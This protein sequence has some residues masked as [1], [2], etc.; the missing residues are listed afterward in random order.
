[1]VYGHRRSNRPDDGRGA[2]G[3]SVSVSSE[4]RIE[5]VVVVMFENRSFDHLLGYLAHPDPSFAGL[6]GG[7]HYN[8]S[9][10]G[11]R[12]DVRNDGTPDL[13]AP[14][15][16]YHGVGLQIGKYGDVAFNGGFVR[17]YEMQ[18]GVANGAQV[19]RCLDPER[20]CPVL[21]RLALQFA[22]C[23]AWFSSVPGETW[24]NRNFAHAATSD[25]AANIE[26]GF[27]YDPTIFEQ[28]SSA[29][30]RWR[31]YH[32]GPPQAWC[33]RNLWRPLTPSEEKTGHEP[34]IGNWYTQQHFFDHIAADDLP[35]YAFIEP[36]H[37]ELDFGDTHIRT[38]SQ[39]PD[40]NHGDARDF[41][42][43][44]QLMRSI[45]AALVARPALFATTLLVITYDEHGGFYDHVR[46]PKATPPADT[47]LRGW[48]RQI[49][50][51]FHALVARISGRPR[52]YGD[53]F[54]FTHLGVRVPTI[55]ISPWIRPGTVVHT[56]LEHAS[57]PATLRALFAPKLGSLTQRDAKAKTFH[58]VVRTHATEQPRDVASVL[59]SIPLQPP[60]SPRVPGPARTPA[61]PAQPLRSDLDAQLLDLSDRVL[62]ELEPP[63]P[64]R[65][66]PQRTGAPG[67]GEA[68]AATS[69]FVR[70]AAAARA[71]RE[72]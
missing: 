10:A 60:L 21:A 64:S 47:V 61:E 4:P 24:P 22:V 8:A 32:D 31:I 39:H 1:M 17:S 70:A 40:H 44:E 59:A 71:R 20:Q 2:G 66:G 33:F 5:H 29:G 57:I 6:Q 19:M 55:L 41:H 49:L 69:A 28:L 72:R 56:Q 26:L 15:H 13:A 23:D 34:R 50:R 11:V 58:D 37:V 62:A 65:P 54:D 63:P 48:T 36:A 38:N 53:D 52:S 25:G 3:V 42:A 12:I 45:F 7:G 27:Y 35:E 16:S 46:P 43:G 18:A 30:A 68:A 14:D 9:G 51:F 67:P